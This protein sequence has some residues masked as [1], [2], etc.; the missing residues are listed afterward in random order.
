MYRFK[1]IDFLTQDNFTNNN[2]SGYYFRKAAANIY[3]SSGLTVAASTFITIGALVDKPV[4]WYITGGICAAGSFLFA[5]IAWNNV[6][7]AGKLMDLNK[8]SALYLTPT[9]E[10]NLGLQIKF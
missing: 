7:R 2:T 9:Q 10:G 3:I 4:G 8:K 6:Y 5:L 1:G